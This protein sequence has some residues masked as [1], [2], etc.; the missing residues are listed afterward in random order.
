MKTPLLTLILLLHGMASFSQTTK[1]DLLGSYV[2]KKI[3]YIY[4]DT[5]IRV[6]PSNKGFLILTPERYAIAYNPGL[7]PRV[8]FGNLSNPTEEEALAG[9]RSFAFNSGAYDYQQQVLTVHPDFAK[10]PGFEGGEQ[11]YIV[12]IKENQL[13]LTMYD[14]TY[15]G[16]EK[17]A[18]YGKLKIQLTFKKEGAF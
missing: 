3:N 4:A 13:V 9:F 2:L 16:G 11:V 7:K 8:P 6:D 17:P 14:E 10:V 5:T 1:E 15:P 12:E 18:W